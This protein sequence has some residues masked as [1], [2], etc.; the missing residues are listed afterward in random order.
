MW[1]NTVPIVAVFAVLVVLLD[2]VLRL[3]L[4]PREP[5]LISQK[6][7]ILGHLAGFLKY[8]SDYYLRTRF[9][10]SPKWQADSILTR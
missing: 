1:S 5:P 10:I 4:D 9:V 2:R 8:G 7:P 3:R 6:I